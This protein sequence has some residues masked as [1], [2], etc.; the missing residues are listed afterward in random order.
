[1][2]MQLDHEHTQT[3]IMPERKHGK[4]I[5]YPLPYPNLP[6]QASASTFNKQI[7]IPKNTFMFKV[8]AISFGNAVVKSLW[9]YATKLN[10]N[11]HACALMMLSH[12]L[13]SSFFSER[14]GAFYYLRGLM[15]LFGS[16]F[17]R[18]MR[19]EV[20]HRNKELRQNKKIMSL[21]SPHSN[22]WCL[23]DIK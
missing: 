2:S 16:P 11:K 22:Y 5:T 1:M 8:I 4:I 7:K 12:E 15:N 19:R 13:S 18:T 21:K 20:R 9:R 17:S 14:V 23:K 6:A 3:G 10:H